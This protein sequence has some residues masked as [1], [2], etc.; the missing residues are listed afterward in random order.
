M[1]GDGGTELLFGTVNGCV[2][3]FKVVDD[4]LTRWRCCE[5]DG[6]VTA[7]CLDDSVAGD[8]KVIVATA[9]GKCSV[10]RS[11]EDAEVLQ[12]CSTFNVVLN[13]CDLVHLNGELVVATRDGRVL[14]YR[15]D[16]ERLEVDE[17]MEYSQVAQLEVG[18]EIES[19]LVLHSTFENPDAPPQLLARCFS[20]GAFCISAPST[21]GPLDKRAVDPWDGP[22]N[23]I[24]GITYVV[25]DVELGGARGMVAVVSMTG[26]VSLFSSSGERQWDVQLPEAVVGADKL[27]MTAVTGERQDAIVVCTW[28]GQLYAIQSERKLVRFRM[29]MPSSS[30]FCVGI[31]DTKGQTDPTVVGIST[32][33]TFFVYRDVQE[34]LIRGLVDSTLADKIAQS[35]LFSEIDTPEKR[36]AILAKLQVTFPQVVTTGTKAPSNMSIAELVSVMLAVPMQP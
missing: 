32:S 20:G 35:E 9:E 36:Q 19:L 4:R 3:V 24:E 13:I 6:S 23:D 31:R 22:P 30:M 28:S 34:T 5:V 17:L 10:F 15:P 21:D 1:D 12:L 18:E 2:S 16:A 33:G 8:T 7:L 14:I 25:A 29:M 11:M 27:E 26:L